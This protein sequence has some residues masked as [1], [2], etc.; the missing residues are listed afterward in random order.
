[1]AL[2]YAHFTVISTS[3]SNAKMFVLNLQSQNN[4]AIVVD[5]KEAQR[6]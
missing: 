5:T 3:G 6:N 2:K 1:M 4:K